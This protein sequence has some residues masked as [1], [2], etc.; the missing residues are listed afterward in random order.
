MK[1]CFEERV[2]KSETEARQQPYARITFHP[3]LYRCRPTGAK[4]SF[5]AFSRRFKHRWMPNIFTYLRNVSKL[6]S[7]LE[8]LPR[9][10]RISI[11]DSRPIATSIQVCHS[12]ILKH[13]RNVCPSIVRPDIW[14]TRLPDPCYSYSYELPSTG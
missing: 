12:T 3:R 14:E 6:G 11:M 1:R 9:A 13:S 7:G 5:L 8:G 10:A 4:S 2:C